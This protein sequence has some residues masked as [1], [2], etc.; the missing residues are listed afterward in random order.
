MNHLSTKNSTW[1]NPLP[2]MDSLQLLQKKHSLCQAKVSKATNLV[3]PRP[4]LPEQNIDN[5]YI[6]TK[7]EITKYDNHL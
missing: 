6:D 1:M 5:D 3:D 7:Y 4:P 2:T